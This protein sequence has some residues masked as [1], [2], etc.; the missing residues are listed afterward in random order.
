M[1]PYIERSISGN[2][3][4]DL[5]LFPAVAL[6]GPRQCGKS[7]LAAKIAESYPGALRLD[8]ENPRDRAKLSDPQLYLEANAS[9]FVCIDE[10]QLVPELFP[11]L[12]SEID[13]ER[14][15]GRFL[16]LGSASRALVNRS[17]ESLAGRIG[18]RELTPFLPTEYLPGS[19]PSVLEAL[20]RGGFPES[21]LSAKGES[22]LRWRESFLKSIVERDL[23]MLGSR[24]PSV[25]MDRF[26][27]MCAHL[28]AQ[29]LNTA[30]LGASLDLSG[31]AVRSRL[32]FL[33]DALFVRLLPSW[34]G[35]LK[36][37]LVKTPKLYIRDT[38]LCHALLGLGSVDD[39]LGHPVFGSSWEALCVETLCS[40]FPDWRPSFYRSSGGAELDLVLERGSRTL[41][42]E[43]KASSAPSPTRGFHSALDDLKPEHSYVLGLID[44]SYPLARDVTACGIRECVELVST[45]T[46]RKAS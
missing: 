39:L 31:P 43:C 29:M 38:G 26:L 15:P 41:A 5:A 6:I 40:S 9:R 45:R 27:G 25:A 33:Q 4:S 2:L 24:I 10:I 36:K 16:I 34:E 3:T 44:G 14:R 20:S 22:S 17:A 46:G 35:N 13:R 18:Y 1:Q 12:R 30:K 19:P 21:A 32:E 7:R 37:R 11:V 28:Q 42:F 8:L 23:P